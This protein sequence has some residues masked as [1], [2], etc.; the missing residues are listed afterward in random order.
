MG[1]DAMAEAL[2]LLE[3][4][5]A[6]QNRMHPGG[7]AISWAQPLL[8]SAANRKQARDF[9]KLQT[10]QPDSPDDLSKN[11]QTAEI[12]RSRERS[13]GCSIRVLSLKEAAQRVPGLPAEQL[14]ATVGP[15]RQLS[16][17]LLVDGAHVIHP[18]RY[19]RCGTLQHPHFPFA[20]P[21]CARVELHRRFGAPLLL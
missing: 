8:R 11:I 21:V 7:E 19:L 14:S 20:R 2:E 5:E 4:A 3:V 17:A 1:H 10:A 18:T 12:D 9:S 6:F 16:A 15:N 13:R